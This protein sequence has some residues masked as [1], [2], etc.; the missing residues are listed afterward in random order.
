[1]YSF[2]QNPPLVDS[3]AELSTGLLN[4]DEFELYSIRVRGVTLAGPGPYS[5]PVFAMTEQDGMCRKYK[6]ALESLDQSDLVKIKWL[7]YVMFRHRM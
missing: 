6:W 3:T 7:L 4:L 5:D 2:L 1:M